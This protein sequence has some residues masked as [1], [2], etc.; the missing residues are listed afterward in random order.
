MSDNYLLGLYRRFSRLPG[1]SRLFSLL[2]SQ[3]A[4]YFG[5]IQPRVKVLRPNYCEV[6]FRKRR[7][8]ENHLQTVHVIAICNALEMA[9]GVLAEASVPAGLRWIP[10][11]MEVRYTAKATSDITAI[12][13]LAPDAWT[14][15][16]EVD[17]NVRAIRTDH[18][19]VVE[20][21]IRLWVTE[22]A[23]R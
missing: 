1:G 8:V 5:S 6:T 15:G 3:R 7:A 20:G 23:K 13:E 10:K 21:K 18:T 19:V 17:V 9:M 11:G 22:K 16:P 2:V 14:R 12:A 4:P